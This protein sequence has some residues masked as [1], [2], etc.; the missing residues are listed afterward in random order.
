[1]LVAHRSLMTTSEQQTKWA[2]VASL[3]H[4][5]RW[6][7]G[8]CQGEECGAL[9][10]NR[11]FPPPNAC[12]P[13]RLLVLLLADEHASVIHNSWW[14]RMLACSSCASHDNA[15]DEEV[16]SALLLKFVLLRFFLVFCS[17]FHTASANPEISRHRFP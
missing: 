7:G 6:W 17:F 16:G 12:A 10:A 5:G 11:G 8:T 13:K 14:R 4:R 2:E 3:C 1:M 15:D 9:P